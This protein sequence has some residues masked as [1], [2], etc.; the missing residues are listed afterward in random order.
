MMSNV[1]EY[2]Y[3]VLGVFSV[4]FQSMESY[5]RGRD[6]EISD[7]AGH[8]K[9]ARQANGGSVLDGDSCRPSML[10]VFC[11]AFSRGVSLPLKVASC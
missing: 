4:C 5:A 9:E 11:N 3:C 10:Q 6:E 7:T 2:V 8:G 1:G